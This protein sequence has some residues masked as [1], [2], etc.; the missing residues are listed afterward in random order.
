MR[1]IL[2]AVRLRRQQNP[3][4]DH[5]WVINGALL[6]HLELIPPSVVVALKNQSVISWTAHHFLSSVLRKI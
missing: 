1:L 2:Q 6:G 3:I 5:L 4:L